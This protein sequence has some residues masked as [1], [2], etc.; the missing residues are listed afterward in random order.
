MIV[1]FPLPD[2]DATGRTIGTSK[3]EAIILPGWRSDPSQLSLLR[4]LPVGRSSST[5]V[6]DEADAERLREVGQA[7]L[8]LAARISVG[9]GCVDVRKTA[10][11]PVSAGGG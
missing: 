6:Q 5:L 11:P 9:M 10:P 2:L 8:E 7:C 4:S 3:A 1:T